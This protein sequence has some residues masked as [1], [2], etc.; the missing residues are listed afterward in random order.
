MGEVWRGVHLSEFAYLTMV[1]NM[2]QHVPKTA[3]HALHSLSTSGP[4]GR[5]VGH[6]QPADQAE[7]D[8]DPAEKLGEEVQ[9][10]QRQES[11]K[12]PMYATRICICAYMW[13]S[14]QSFAENA[15]TLAVRLMAF[16]TFVN[17]FSISFLDVP[18]SVFKP[19]SK[20]Q[21]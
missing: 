9:N 17:V 21:I 20:S 19:S 1:D 14:F 3:L 10:L 16:R 7:T 2:I 13:L 11:N 4:V 12:D 8:A 18:A 15:S 6:D 5:Q